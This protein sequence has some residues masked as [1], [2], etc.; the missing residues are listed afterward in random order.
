MDSEN[1]RELEAI[2]D[3]FYDKTTSKHAAYTLR[4]WV[5]DEKPA[6]TNISA[7]ASDWLAKCKQIE[8]NLDWKAMRALLFLHSLGPSFQTF[9][10][11]ATSSD[12]PTDLQDLIRRA[13]D[14]GRGRESDEREIS[15]ALQCTEKKA[16]PRTDH[17]GN[18]DQMRPCRNCGDRYHCRAECFKPGGGLSHMT[19]EEKQDWVDARRRRREQNAKK[20]KRPSKTTEEANLCAQLALENKRLREKMK[21]ADK[22]LGEH[23]YG[24]MVDL[25]F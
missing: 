20:R 8:A 22:T 3:N 19:E 10:D 11:I 9:F 7:W 4:A 21:S 6:R 16:P 1:G 2:L 14:H 18:G 5:K 15:R 17:H 13:E 24:G 23:G 25:E 12:T